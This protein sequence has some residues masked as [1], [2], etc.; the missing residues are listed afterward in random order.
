MKSFQ[1]RN[2]DI[3]NGLDSCV[4]QVKSISDFKNKLDKNRYKDGTVP[5]Q[6]LSRKSQVGKHSW[7]NTHVNS[8]QTSPLSTTKQGRAQRIMQ[9]GRM[10]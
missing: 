2:V 6:L 3:W 4:A 7:V 1:H 10:R 8:A 9:R 5:A